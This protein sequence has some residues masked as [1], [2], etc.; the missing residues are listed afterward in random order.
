MQTT[1][2]QKPEKLLRL[3]QVLERVPIGRSTL[4]AWISQG[5]FP[6]PCK[7]GSMTVWRES[8]IDAHIAQLGSES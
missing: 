1:T 5:K 8:D 2:P 4:W 7:L 6:A 3:P